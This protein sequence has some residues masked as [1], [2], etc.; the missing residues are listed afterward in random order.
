MP[1]HIAFLRAINVAGR[2]LKMADLAEHF[3]S[4]GHTQVQTHINSGNVLFQPKPAKKSHARALEAS[5]EAGLEPLLGFKSEVFV[6]TGA[7]SQAIA[8]QALTHL[9][10]TPS[11]KEVNVAFLA[12][13]LTTSQQADLQSL[14][15]PIDSF[16]YDPAGGR[17]IYW[18]CHVKQSD[19]KFSNAALERRL[20]IRTTFRRATML[21]G[22]SV[23]FEAPS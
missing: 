1:H 11:L 23:L 15:T 8:K 5:L 6:R 3:R 2:Y 13:T 21:Q 4:L 7:E 10:K 9:V 12:S 19:S 22:V 20:K 14:Q 16:V 18:L 17:E